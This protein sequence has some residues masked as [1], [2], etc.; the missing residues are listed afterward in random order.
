M[1]KIAS[2]SAYVINFL[3]AHELARLIALKQVSVLEAVEAHLQQITRMNPQLNAFTYLRTE[4]ALR[5][6]R[7]AQ[8]RIMRGDAL[9]PLLGVPVTIKSCIDLA[10]LRCEAGSRLRTGYLPVQDAPLVARL[11]RA[12]AIVIGN[13]NTPELLMAYE[14]DNAITG[15]TS[16]PWSLGRSAGGS[17]GGEAAAIAAG[18]SALGIG[19]DGGGSIRVPAHFCGI[20]GLKPTP[21]RIPGTGHFP[22]CVGPFGQLGVVGPMARSIRDL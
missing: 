1:C 12:G 3:A 2:G 14:T 5:E 8:E 20:A 16:N 18:C 7:A 15:R 4:E 17:S 13:T 22:A 11:K 6:A 19:S 10:G 9:P 21:G